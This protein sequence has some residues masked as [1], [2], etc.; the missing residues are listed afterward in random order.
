MHA[1]LPNSHSNIQYG[2]TSLLAASAKGHLEAVKLLLQYGADVDFQSSVNTY[3]QCLPQ[4]L[5]AYIPTC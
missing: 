5:Q 3:Y 1:I 2:Y 4:L